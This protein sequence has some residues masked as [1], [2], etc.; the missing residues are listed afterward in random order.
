MGGCRGGGPSLTAAGVMWDAGS[1]AAVE[2][3]DAAIEDAAVGIDDYVAGLDAALHGPNR[4]R[5]DLVAEARH[6]L[7]DAAEAYRRS[8][9]SPAEAAGRAVAE[10]GEYRQVV[11]GYQAELA[12]A[13]GR[14]TALLIALALPVLTVLAPLMWWHG[15]WPG[16]P[17]SPYYLRLAQAFDYLSLGGGVVA[18]LV[19]VGFGPGSRYIADGVRLTRALGRGTLTFLVVHGLAGGGV[20]LWSVSL[21]PAALRWP[22]MWLGAVVMQVGFGYAALCGWRCLRASR[23]AAR[24]ATA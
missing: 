19:L 6:S 10:F 7:I 3:E 22:P 17:A 21:W 15:P 18:A 4:V 11:P 24:A 20:Y 12:V 23:V 9:L 2:I 13:Q 8:G 5:E 16:T 14:R 1:V